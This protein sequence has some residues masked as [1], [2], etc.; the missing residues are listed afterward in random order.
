[1]T[2]VLMGTVFSL[3]LLEGMLSLLYRG[4]VRYQEQQ[5]RAAVQGGDDEVR[6]LCIGESTTA[7]A[8]DETG[9]LLVPHTSYPMQLQRI[10]NARQSDV[11]FRV[12]NSG[13]MGGTT[14]G[15]MAML[16][17][18]M[19]AYQPHI[20]IAM[21]GIKDT[22][23]LL[24]PGLEW[25]PD[26]VR[27]LRTVQLITWA[28]EAVRLRREATG[29]TVL[30]A[31]DIT[32]LPDGLRPGHNQLSKFVKETR[33]VGPDADIAADG[34]LQVATHLWFTDR[35][36]AA[37]DRLQRIITEHGV[38]AN[39]LARVLVTN[40][41]ADEAERV[42]RRAIAA[43]PEEGMYRVEL[44][45]VLVDQGRLDDADA[46]L[47]EARAEL[48]GF[49]RPALV[50][51]YITLGQAQVAQERGQHDE[52][53]S[54]LDEMVPS[55]ERDQANKAYFP[56]AGALRAIALGE[57][58]AAVG[59]LDKAEEQ[60]TLALRQRPGAHATMWLLG[61]VYRAQGRF[62][63]EKALR[64]KLIAKRQRMAEYYELAKLF[65]L[66]GDEARISD[67]FDEGLAQ[68]PSIGANH[69]RLYAAAERAGVQ[70]IVMQYPS[71]SLELLHKY[72]PEADG[73]VF[74]DNEHIF[75]AD[76]DRYF[77]EPRFPNS[78]SH[79]TVEGA[80]LLAEHVADTVLEVTAAQFPVALP[81][82]AS[83][84][85]R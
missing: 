18:A 8:G 44:A 50:G 23:D 84:P 42:M 3:V 75:D 73:V 46:V 5:N 32:D 56:Q 9:R 61:K 37:V 55:F 36:A 68:I 76:P 71:F 1:M 48:D 74:I 69:R 14:E 57:S 7:V 27:A 65:R 53:I 72:A 43:V 66:N 11:R 54:I 80:A 35:H 70:L 38:G 82:D 79:Y 78:F 51:E 83:Q 24:Q 28:T 15:V 29:A 49:W 31:D 33:M 2:T 21:M 62:S 64:R 81:P 47:A 41:Q 59:E 13:M 17:P 19:E 4:F 20:I 25:L 63:D 58:F 45:A 77:F 12:I 39:L 10:L 60:L 6:V 30:N 22:A 67:L 85:R 40:R 26:G 34:D 16:G 52:V